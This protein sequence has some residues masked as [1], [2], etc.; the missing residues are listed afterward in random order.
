MML[1]GYQME[2]GATLIMSL[3]LLVL[4][5]LIV[6][7]AFTLSSTNLKAVAN[8][9]ARDEAIAAANKA[10]EQVFSSNFTVT[11]V[12]EAINVDIDNDSTTDYVVNVAMPTCVRATLD[13]PPTV[14][15]ISLGAALSSISTWNTVWDVEAQVE[16]QRSGVRTTVNAGIRV[17]MS[18][19][20]KD[21]VCP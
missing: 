11:P 8:M 3:I 5:T 19:T 7:T 21:A 13:T 17:T 18:Q 14:S 16:D 6:T 4:I 9:Q 10:V 20:Q 12:A 2:R 1:A 15:S